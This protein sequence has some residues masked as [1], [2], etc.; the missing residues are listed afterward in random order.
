LQIFFDVLETR[1]VVGPTV[2]DNCAFTN[3]RTSRAA[4][5]ENVKNFMLNKECVEDKEKRIEERDPERR[6][7]AVIS[8][9]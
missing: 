1:V 3:D 4:R 5:N 2:P 7:E 9:L 6:S 8:L